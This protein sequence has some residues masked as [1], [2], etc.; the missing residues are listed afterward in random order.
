MA[1]L[2]KREAEQ[3][4]QSDKPTRVPLSERMRGKFFGAMYGSPPN[5]IED[6]QAKHKGNEEGHNKKD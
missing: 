1:A 4:A 5:P 3:Q 6:E 2:S